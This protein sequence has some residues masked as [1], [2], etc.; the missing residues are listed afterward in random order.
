MSTILLI[1][2][3]TFDY[4]H[5][6]AREVK[7]GMGRYFRLPVFVLIVGGKIPGISVRATFVFDGQDT[8]SKRFY[9]SVGKQ[10]EKFE[11]IKIFDNYKT[12][13]RT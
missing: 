7:N 10:L 13:N 1:V 5:R 8:N 12:S 3:L 4:Q 2:N 9:R 11:D 6:I